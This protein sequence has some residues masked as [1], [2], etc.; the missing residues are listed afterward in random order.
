MVEVADALEA[1]GWRCPCDG[2]FRGQSRGKFRDGLPFRGA[3]HYLFI[4][5]AMYDVTQDQAWMQRYLRQRNE[6]PSDSDKTR[7]EICAEGYAADRGMLKNLEPGLLW[8]YVGAQ[9]ALRKLFELETD[10]TVR[11]FYR[12]GLDR[13][14]ANVLPF[15][16]AC[17]QFDNRND[18]GFKYANWREGYTWRPQ[19]T[20]KDAEQVA[21]S[22]K[23]EIL[24]TRKRYERLTMTS[25]LS[26]AAIAALAGD[27]VNRNAIELAIRHYDY[28][29]INLSE[30]FLAE[31]A[32]YALPPSGRP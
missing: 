5:R 3:S 31:C 30:F 22:G 29:K 1:V 16:A 6:R 7:L 13:N 25:P 27:S 18:E 28:T 2:A 20:Q 9:G 8:I 26:A 4:L 10:E 24:G 15:I 11:A 21:R 23:M 17:Q 19:N 32:Y 12:Q 14:A